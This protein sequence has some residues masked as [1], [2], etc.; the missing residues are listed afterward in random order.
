ME[1]PTT[2][3]GRAAGDDVVEAVAIEVA[4][5]DPVPFDEF[6]RDTGS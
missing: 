2:A 1:V 4:H 3:A 5:A 6:D